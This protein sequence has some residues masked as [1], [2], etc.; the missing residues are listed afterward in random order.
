MITKCISYIFIFYG[1]G[2]NLYSKV[3]FFFLK[4]EEKK[5]FE[6]KIFNINYSNYKMIF[7]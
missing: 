6:K 2:L 3:F 1:N 5:D 7:N 4:N